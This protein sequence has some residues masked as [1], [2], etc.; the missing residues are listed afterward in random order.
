MANGL[1]PWPVRIAAFLILVAIA[2]AAIHQVDK[3]A[4]RK[5][6][7]VEAAEAKERVDQ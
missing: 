2:L 6:Q 4:V 1:S 5:Q 3:R 7:A